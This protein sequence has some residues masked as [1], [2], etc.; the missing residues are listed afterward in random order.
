MVIVGSLMVI[1]H[2]SAR[3]PLASLGKPSYAGE[4]EY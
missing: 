4:I 2:T 1:Y 3:Q